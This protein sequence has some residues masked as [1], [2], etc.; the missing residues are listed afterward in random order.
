MALHT[1]IVTADKVSQTACFQAQEFWVEVEEDKLA[2]AIYWM[3]K[4][5]RLHTDTAAL[6]LSI[7]TFKFFSSKFYVW[8]SLFLVLAF[9]FL[10]FSINQFT[11]KI[12]WE[13]EVCPNLVLCECSMVTAGLKHLSVTTELKFSLS[14]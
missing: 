2:D 6:A 5:R 3:E 7:D 13:D 14:I 12:I 11:L 1:C 8:N 4:Q 9:G 10:L